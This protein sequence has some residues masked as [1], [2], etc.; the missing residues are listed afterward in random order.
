MAFSEVRPGTQQKVNAWANGQLPNPVPRS[1]DFAA[2]N[3]TQSFLNR[4]PGSRLLKQAG[5][6]FV[7]TSAS[8]AWPDGHV[9]ISPGTGAGSDLAKTI[10]IPVVGGALVL[11]AAGFAF[12]AW[13]RSR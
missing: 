9:T 2:P 1:V 13:R 3:V 8:L 5:N 4:T 10:A 12:W 6:W 7:G 11:A